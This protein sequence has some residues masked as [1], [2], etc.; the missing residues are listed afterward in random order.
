MNFFA[1]IKNLFFYCS[2]FVLFFPSVFKFLDSG[3]EK[4]DYLPMFAGMFF[5]VYFFR[6]AREAS[7]RIPVGVVS[8]AGVK[9]EMDR[10]SRKSKTF[11][12]AVVQGMEQQI[13]ENNRRRE[14]Q[15]KRIFKVSGNFTD[16]LEAYNMDKKLLFSTKYINDRLGD[17]ELIRFSEYTVAYK[18]EDKVFVYNTN[19]ERLLDCY[20]YEGIQ[21]KI[22]WIEKEQKKKYESR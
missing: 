17:M 15:R 8:S 22:K 9:I 6:I 18:V 1:R 10:P 14:L 2:A 16:V 20:Y 4:Y 7:S 21:D 3:P 12:D 13:E 5:G 11:G 19:N